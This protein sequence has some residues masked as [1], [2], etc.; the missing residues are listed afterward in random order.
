M[1]HSGEMYLPPCFMHIPP[2]WALFLQ[3]SMEHCTFC[4]FFGDGLLLLLS[5]SLLSASSPLLLI[6]SRLP[7]SDDGSSSSCRLDIWGRELLIL[8]IV[9]VND[10]ELSCRDGQQT[11][12]RA[13]RLGVGLIFIEEV[14]SGKLSS[15][16]S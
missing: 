8:L 1:M 3:F 15:A 10:V 5:S 16:K 9:A 11:F 12:D 13:Y 14:E 6:L 4:F 2:S 7:A